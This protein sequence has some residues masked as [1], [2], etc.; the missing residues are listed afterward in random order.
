MECEGHEAAEPLWQESPQVQGSEATKSI[1]SL[2]SM[3]LV[4]PPRFRED[5]DC[6]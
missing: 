1:M 6:S 5:L 3:L 4:Q 2:S